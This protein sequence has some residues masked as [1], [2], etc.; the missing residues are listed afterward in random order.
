M[1]PGVKAIERGT[2][3]MRAMA[4]P[5]FCLFLS[6]EPNMALAA[7]ESPPVP[8]RQLV[9]EVLSGARDARH[10]AL[11][12]LQ[13]RGKTDVVAALIQGLR[14]FRA[15]PVL[16]ATLEAL[17]GARHGG[18]WQAWMR[19][20]EAHPE[21]TAFDGFDGFKADLLA[22]IDPAFRLFLR[23]GVAHTI[24]LEEIVWGGV[25][26]DGIPALVDPALIT[27]AAAGYLRVDELVFGV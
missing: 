19:W 1:G 2:A 20:Q 9:D 21:I 10:R 11:A 22:G 4:A 27:A 25:A 8:V 23:R 15:D 26:K 3:M 5:V 7:E 12:A 6:L 16:A 18:D 17:T 24:R 14:F 13:Q